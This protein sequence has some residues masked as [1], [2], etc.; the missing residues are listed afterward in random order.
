MILQVTKLKVWPDFFIIGAAKS[1]T[2][3]LYEYL[4]RHPEI[5]L[6]K[7]KEPN[8]F[9][10]VHLQSR[11]RHLVVNIKEDAEYHRIFRKATSQQLIGEGS[12]SYLFCS[13]APERIFKI[14]PYAKFLAV[15]RDP[16]ERAYSHYW[17]DVAVGQQHQDF[18]NA[19]LTDLMEKRRYWGTARLYVDLGLYYQQLIR[20]FELFPS[21][22]VKI[23]YQEDLMNDAWSVMAD[24][25]RFLGVN[26]DI[27]DEMSFDRHHNEFSLPA[28]NFSKFI[29]AQRNLRLMLRMIIP[30]PVRRA[31][32][33][34]VLMSKAQKPIMALEDRV[35]MQ[36]FFEED[37]N[38]IDQLPGGNA[39]R[40]KKQWV[41]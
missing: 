18:R 9:A 28:G 41:Y 12:V 1:G 16:V 35:F 4:R 6:P 22:N 8:Y 21:D 14:N 23:I 17:M 36:S 26:V 31:V 37:I 7:I 30:Q 29:V 38:K 27:F 34:S 24:V 33:D 19:V 25:G 10:D 39:A 13:K 5:F 20:Y 15:L 2:T 3:S 11:Y 40:L 32:L